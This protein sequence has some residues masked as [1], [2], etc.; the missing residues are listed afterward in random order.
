MYRAQIKHRTQTAKSTNAAPVLV[1]E[2][3]VFLVFI[4]VLVPVLCVFN[5]SGSCLP[6]SQSGAMWY[7]GALCF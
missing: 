2:K 4:W 1:F 6:R 3:F 5:R 7:W